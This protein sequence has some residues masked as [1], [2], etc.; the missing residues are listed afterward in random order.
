MQC[1][2]GI[3]LL[4]HRLH[5]F[6]MQFH[7]DAFESFEVLEP[8]LAAW[9]TEWTDLSRIYETHW[10]SIT[11]SDP[12]TLGHSAAVIGRPSPPNLKKVDYYPSAEFLF[13]V[14][15]VRMLDCWRYTVVNCSSNIN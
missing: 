6:L 13:L 8:T 7:E 4:E 10:D 3:E 2:E 14:L 15:D 12:S 5:L 11:S 1:L 9:H